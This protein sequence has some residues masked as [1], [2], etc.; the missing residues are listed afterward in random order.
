MI[1]IHTHPVMIRELIEEEPGLARAVREVFGLLFPPQPLQVF[2]SELDAAGVERAVLLPLD[3]TT[4]HGCRIVTNEQV[5]SLAE[6]HPRLLGFASVDPA[7]REA[8]KRLERAIRGLGLRGLKLDPALQRF[9]LDSREQAYPLYQA[10][11]ELGV[12]I[13]V[14]CGLSWSMVGQAKYARPLALEEVAQEFPGLRLVIAHCGW[15]WVE[16]ALLLALKYP[17]VYLDTAVIYSGTPG[18]ALRRVLGERIGLEVLERSLPRQLLFGSNYP[19]QDIRRAVRG[20]RALPL[21]PGLAQNLF[22][23]NAA[24]LLGLEGGRR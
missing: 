21:S 13:L 3:C 23:A 2:L 10:C 11:S 15:P 22:Q 14:H 7:V 8:P 6:K 20:L 1:D 5:A 4:A 12:P 9:A 18:E 24:S 17:N 19:R 16:E